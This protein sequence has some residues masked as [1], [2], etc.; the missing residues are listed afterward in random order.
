MSTDAKNFESLGTAL[1]KGTR[2]LK[3]PFDGLIAMVVH[4]NNADGN[5]LLRELRRAGCVA[6]GVWPPPQ[7]PSKGLGA[8]ICLLAHGIWE[9]FLS[10]SDEISSPLIGVVQDDSE[11]LVT[12]VRTCRP[13]AVLYKPIVPA[14]VI[15]CLFLARQ[16]FQYQARLR[17][18]V[19]KLDDTLRAL[20][21]VERAK[22]I[23]METR[24]L[25]EHSAYHFMRKQAMEKRVPIGAI[26]S[27]IIDA[28]QILR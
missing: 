20:R 1:H 8:L 16:L 3:Q 14:Q 28:Y 2:Q 26:A 27:T 22:A 5:T 9:N 23:L 24:N 25:D 21:D 11:D 15:P 4:P 19:A 7:Q 10:Q 18:R 12:L 6:R 17:R 13:H